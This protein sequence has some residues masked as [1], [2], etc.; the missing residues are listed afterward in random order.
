MK[1][2]IWYSVDD[3][4]HRYTLEGE[5]MLCAEDCADDFHNQ[6][7]GWECSWPKTFVLYDSATSPEMGRYTVEREVEPVF[8]ATKA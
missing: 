7:D 8:Y 3:D 5:Y 1:Y 2:K 6:H 4:E